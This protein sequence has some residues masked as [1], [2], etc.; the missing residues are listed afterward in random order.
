MAQ[1]QESVCDSSR[2]NLFE[3][4]DTCLQQQSKQALRMLSGLE[5]EGTECILIL[6]ALVRECR[7]LT[8]IAGEVA[9]GVSVTTAMANFKVWATRKND[10]PA[11]DKNI[12]LKLIYKSYY[13]KR[14]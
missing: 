5:N 12:T 2:Y 7:L 6:W 1:V 9:Q 8:Q 11:S 14:I 4:V 3:F 13:K 10:C